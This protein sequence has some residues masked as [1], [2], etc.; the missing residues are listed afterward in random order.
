MGPLQQP[1]TKIKTK[2]FL[3]KKKYEVYEVVKM[4]NLV[5]RN[6]VR[7]SLA[8]SRRFGTSTARKGFHGVPPVGDN[9]PFQ[10]ENR[11]RFTLVFSAFF[12]SGFA[13]PFLLVR[14]QLLK[15]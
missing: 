12:G 14:H 13:V 3:I 1:L 5:T 11:W 2:L 7:S 9:V 6:L 8:L 15:K 10:F 4:S